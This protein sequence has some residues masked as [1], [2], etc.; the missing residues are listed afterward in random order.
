MI[1]DRSTET[2]KDN[3]ETFKDNIE[4]FKDNIETFDDQWNCK[5][6]LKRYMSYLKWY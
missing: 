2:F 1:T 5:T 6:R 4:T 3:T